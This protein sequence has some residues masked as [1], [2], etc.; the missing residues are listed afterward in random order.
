MVYK[1]IIQRRDAEEMNRGLGMLGAGRFQWHVAGVIGVSQNID[2]RV[3]ETHENVR[4]RH[5]NSRERAEAHYKDSS[6]VAQQRRQRFH[7]DIAL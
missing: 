5:S 7:T 6:I 2:A 4:H 3:W 1:Q